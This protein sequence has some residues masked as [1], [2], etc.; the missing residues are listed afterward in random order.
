MDIVHQIKISTTPDRVYQA[1]TS[2]NGI[3]SWW[4]KN[5]EIATNIGSQHTMNFLKEGQAIVMKFK[6]D[7]LEANQKV[8]WQCTYNDN[9][10]WVK[11]NLHFELMPEEN[12]TLLTFSHT[13]WDEK[14]K[15]T[16]LY[17]SVGP[18]WEAFMGSLKSFCE[19]GIG[20]PW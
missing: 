19:T 11:T 20:Q 16:P 14:Y 7:K 18:T 9:P 4:C 1:I 2:S 6:I 8:G 3:Q 13:G 10:A 12:K 15:G 5:S 17:V